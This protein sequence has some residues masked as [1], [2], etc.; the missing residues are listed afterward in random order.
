MAAD[1]KSSRMC[2]RTYFIRDPSCKVVY[3]EIASLVQGSAG[4][5]GNIGCFLQPKVE[6]VASASDAALVVSLT[7][8]GEKALSE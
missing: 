3:K 8:E 1:S 2:T 7:S 4:D 6:M 5:L